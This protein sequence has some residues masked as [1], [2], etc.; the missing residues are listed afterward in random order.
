MSDCTLGMLRGYIGVPGLAM[1]NGFLEMCDPFIHVGILPGRLRMLKR[2]LSMLH[3]G[4]G[5]A[6][7]A[8]RHCLLGMFQSFRRMLVS[9]KGE[10]AKEWE[11]DK[12][13]NRRNDQC[14][15]MDSD[16]HGF[17]LSS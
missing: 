4:I 7:F 17:L 16:F 5:M 9:G 8:M 12:R 11:A 6:L 14:S 10:P 13:G 1:G 15:A 2:F 3:Q